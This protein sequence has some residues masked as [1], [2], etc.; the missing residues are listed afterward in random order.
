MNPNVKLQQPTVSAKEINSRQHLLFVLKK[1]SNRTCRG[2]PAVGTLTLLSLRHHFSLTKEK[3]WTSLR[4]CFRSRL[5]NFS[6]V[7]G[8][9][10]SVPDSKLR[11]QNELNK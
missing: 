4:K 8:R 9:A 6:K 11:I 2:K 7:S 1:H 3:R 5:K 10:Q